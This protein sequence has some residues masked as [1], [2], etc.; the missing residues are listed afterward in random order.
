MLYDTNYVECKNICFFQHSIISHSID[1]VTNGKRISKNQYQINKYNF[2]IHLKKYIIIAHRYRF[3]RNDL[4]PTRDNRFDCRLEDVCWSREQ[5][6]PT[7][8]RHSP[9]QYNYGSLFLQSICLIGHRKSWNHLKRSAWAARR[10]RKP[11]LTSNR[12]PKLGFLPTRE[13]TPERVRERKLGKLGRQDAKESR[14]WL[15]DVDACQ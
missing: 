14:V 9:S 8:Q 10:R 15:V 7:P 3:I 4:Q 5:S 13:I 6:G 1:S 11:P 12:K 2:R